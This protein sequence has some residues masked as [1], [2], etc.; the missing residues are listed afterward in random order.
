M[1]KMKRERFTALTF[2]RY[3][4]LPMLLKRVMLTPSGVNHLLPLVA[5]LKFADF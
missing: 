5:F 3:L 2:S 1:H 4:Q